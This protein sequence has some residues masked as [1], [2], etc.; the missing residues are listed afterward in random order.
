M[1]IKLI[2]ILFFISTSFLFSQEVNS[3]YY[4]LI[5][6]G[7]SL[8]WAKDYKNSAINYSLAFKTLEWK[9][10]ADDRY[11]AACSWAMANITDSAF[12]HLNRLI[13]KANFAEYDRV[14]NDYNLKSLHTDKRWKEYLERIEQNILPEGCFRSGNKANSYFMY[15]AHGAGKAGQDV[16]TIK[17]K[18]DEID[19]F[20]TLLQQSLPPEFLGKKIR[21]TCNMKS[22]HVANWA[23]IWLRVDQ[24]DKD[25]PKQFDNMQDR[26]IKGTTDWQQYEIVLFVPK[27]ATKIAFGAVITGTGQIWFDKIEFEIVDES[28]P[29]TGVSKDKKTK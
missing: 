26:P 13:T 15:I 3:D 4:S 7:D 27:K 21:M 8:Y 18:E 5:R 29:N 16:F 14:I 2:I 24:P 1:T 25:A 12:Y 22:E 9:G 28:V 23:G 6:K 11:K 17:S 20:G 19:G 10:Y